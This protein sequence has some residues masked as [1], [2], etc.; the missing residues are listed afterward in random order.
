MWSMKSLKTRLLIRALYN[1]FSAGT[2][3][4]AGLAFN[5]LF[6]IASG[7]YKIGTKGTCSYIL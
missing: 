5:P 4:K 7:D 1:F 3:G 2:I 6:L